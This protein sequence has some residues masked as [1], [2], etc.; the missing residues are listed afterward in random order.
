MWGGNRMVISDKEAWNW[1]DLLNE[2]VFRQRW[3]KKLYL[4]T[5]FGE[6][7]ST[8]LV[9]VFQKQDFDVFRSEWLKLLCCCRRTRS[10]QDGGSIARGRGLKG[11]SRGCWKAQAA[12]NLEGQFALVRIDVSCRSFHGVDLMTLLMC[13]RIK[14]VHSYI[15]VGRGKIVTEVSVLRE[16]VTRLSRLHWYPNRT[17][18]VLKEGLVG[19]Q[20]K[21]SART[22]ALSMYPYSTLVQSHV[23]SCKLK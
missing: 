8:S 5:L 20:K 7:V 19:V 12:R 2:L 10:R 11:S 4:V 9:H 22:Y 3:L 17:P 16:C 14:R 23:R 18:Q 6:D 15:C 21:L 1:P 13:R